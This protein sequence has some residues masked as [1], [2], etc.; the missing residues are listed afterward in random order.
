MDDDIFF[1]WG[2]LITMFLVFAFIL[3]LRQVFRNRL[4][5]REEELRREQEA[6]EIAES[7][8]GL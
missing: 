6:I 1:L 8:S 4:A 2:T 7:N 5:E 3:T